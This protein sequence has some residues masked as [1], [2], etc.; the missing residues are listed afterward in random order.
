MKNYV[1]SGAANGIGKAIVLSLVREGHQVFAL[2]IDEQNLNLLKLEAPKQIHTYTIDVTDFRAIERA[3]LPVVK[4]QTLFGV[5]LSHGIDNEHTISEN[6]IWDRI[7]ATNLTSTQRLLSLLCP[8]I[9]NGGRV[10]MISSI[11]GKVGRKNN[12]AYCA[13]KHALLGITKALA[14][15][16]APQRITVNAVL[17]SWVDTKMLREGLAQQARMMGNT[18][19]LLLKRI[20]KRIPLG[21]LISAEDV[22]GSVN[23]LLSPAAVMI[24]AQSLVIDGGDGCGV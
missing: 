9:S 10:V 13:S 19:P 11:L 21:R 20:G 18:V 22:A 24:T 17:P 14:L 2:D 6:S 8:A 16:L 5:I 7:I 12:S 15:E 4:E 1:V 23:F 3:L